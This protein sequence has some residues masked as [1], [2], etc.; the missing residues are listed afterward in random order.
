MGPV[1]CSSKLT[2]HKKGIVEIYGLY[3]VSQKQQPGLVIGIWSR[4]RAIL[5]YWG[6]KLWDLMQSPGG[7]S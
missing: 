1:N 7:V 5:Q 2:E 4:G 6:L 3:P